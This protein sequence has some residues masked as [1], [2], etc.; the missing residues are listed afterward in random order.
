MFTI[1][2]LGFCFLFVSKLNNYV[3]RC[4]FAKMCYCIHPNKHA[5]LYYN[6]STTI[7]SRFI[8]L[9]CLQSCLAKLNT[10]WGI[11]C[12]KWYMI[13]YRIIHGSDNICYLRWLTTSYSMDAR[14]RILLFRHCELKTLFQH[15]S[16]AN[17]ELLYCIIEGFLGTHATKNREK[18]HN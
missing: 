8:H 3:I 1:E 13:F 14:Y 11:V 15:E 10:I 2:F 7:D 9:I 18:L 16:F 4:L 6:V 17:H 12:F 5:I